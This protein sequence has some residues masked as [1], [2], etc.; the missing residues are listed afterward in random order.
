MTIIIF[1][2]VAIFIIFALILLCGAEAVNTVS[3]FCIDYQY[4]FLC[5]I[6]LINLFL[7][8]FLYEEYKSRPIRKIIFTA[9]ITAI[10]T[11]LCI[12]I[13]IYAI[14]SCYAFVDSYHQNPLVTIFLGMF[15]FILSYCIVAL[16]MSIPILVLSFSVSVI[17]DFDGEK[18]VKSILLLLLNIVIDFIFLFALKHFTLYMFQ[19]SYQNYIINSAYGF[20]FELIP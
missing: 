10:S 15:D 19:N 1:G 4:I 6:V 3:N 8:F 20:I 13:F 7:N 12:S 18:I 2:P 9:L 17:S 16:I 11:I 14:T 5:V